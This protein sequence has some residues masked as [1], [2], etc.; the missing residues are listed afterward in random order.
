MQPDVTARG[1]KRKLE[2]I[3]CHSTPMPL[4]YEGANILAPM[5]RVGTLPMRWVTA[6]YGCDIVYTEEMIDR[7]CVVAACCLPFAGTERLFAPQST[8]HH[9]G[10]QRRARHDRLCGQERRGARQNGM[11][12]PSTTHTCLPASWCSEPLLQRNTAWWRK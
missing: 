5:V 3:V 2:P 10:S 4:N 6:E 8:G 9:G 1:C 12:S 7:K 11:P